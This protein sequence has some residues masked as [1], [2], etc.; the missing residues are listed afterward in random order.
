[1]LADDDPCLVS[2]MTESIL[3]LIPERSGGKSHSQG[4]QVNT[5]LTVT[6]S[7]FLYFKLAFAE[8]TN[9]GQL[10]VLI[11]ASSRYRVS[12]ET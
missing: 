7:Y 8:D 12:H 4:T 5:C 3:P 6:F 9:K 11:R 2:N 1:M 10:I